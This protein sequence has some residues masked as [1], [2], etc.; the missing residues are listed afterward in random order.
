MRNL[1]LTSKFFFLFLLILLLIGGASYS[2]L[3]NIY[4]DQL[5][6]QGR[7]IADNVQAFG[8]W[9][10]SYGRVWVKDNDK[11]FL[12]H[13]AVT[14]AEDTNVNVDFYAKNPALAQRE[15]SEIVESLPVK[16]KFR[17]TSHNFMNPVNVP[18]NFEANALKKVRAEKLEE[19]DDVIN[20]TYRYAR[21]VIH[22]ATC[23]KCHGDPENAP[24]DVTNKY[25]TKNGFGFKEGD[26]AGIISVRIPT[27]PLFDSVQTFFGYKEIVLIITAFLVA[28]FFV[29]IQVINPIVRLTLASDQISTGKNINLHTSTIHETTGNEIDQLALSINRLRTTVRVAIKRIKTFGKN[30]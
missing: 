12:G 21:T 17:M 14:S 24:A 30:R 4:Y 6:D 22:K 5:K 7:N 15:Y 13:L 3:R 19:Y 8:T 1:S 2:V 25:G 29:R 18:D 26:V 20:G 10:A 23:I 16:A 28:A 9:V 11:S 27:K